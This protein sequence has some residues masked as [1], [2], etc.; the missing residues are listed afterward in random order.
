MH[1]C[2]LCNFEGEL[3]QHHLIPKKQGGDDSINNLIN[4]CK[5]CHYKLHHP[6]WEDG[7]I[8]EFNEVYKKA[9]DDNVFSDGWGILPRKV[10]LDNTISLFARLLYSELSSLCAERGYCWASNKYLA[11]KFKVSDKTVSRAITEL[12]KYIVIRN[13]TSQKRTIWVHTLNSK[14]RKLNIDKP[15]QN[16]DKPVQQPGQI[17]LGNLDKNVQH[18]N[19]NNNKN[20]NNK[21]NI[22]NTPQIKKFSKRDDI[23][24]IVVEELSQKYDCPASFVW[25]CWDSACNWM[26]ANGK[27]KKNYKAFLDN[28]VKAEVIKVKSSKKGFSNGVRIAKFEEYRD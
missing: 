16:I 28:W 17:C 22:E 26:D 18:N 14:P 25:S 24:E 8:D 2:N 23:T 27:T 10:A 4:I 21:L 15:V 3:D 7:E 9:I 11:G 1:K 19:I 13:R 6:E 12:E 5:D 20:K